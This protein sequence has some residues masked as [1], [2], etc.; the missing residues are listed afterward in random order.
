MTDE[1]LAV[2]DEVER[3][4]AE[5]QTVDICFE[6]WHLKAMFL[7]EHDILW[8]SPAALNPNVMFD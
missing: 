4:I 5:T 3:C 6:Y 8:R 1:Y 2:I 7:W